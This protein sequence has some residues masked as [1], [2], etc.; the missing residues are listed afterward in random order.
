MQCRKPFDLHRRLGLAQL[1]YLHHLL[2]LVRAALREERLDLGFKHHRPRIRSG[3]PQTPRTKPRARSAGRDAAGEE[4]ATRARAPWRARL[5]GLRFGTAISTMPI[6]PTPGGSRP[7]DPRMGALS[8]AVDPFYG[9]P[10]LHLAHCQ[11]SSCKEA[12]HAVRWP[13]SKSLRRSLP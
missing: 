1:P 11:D 8:A 10:G 5:S 9:A 12:N 2:G 4:D 13:C 7:D 6:P 3:G